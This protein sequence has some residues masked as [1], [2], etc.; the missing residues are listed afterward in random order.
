MKRRRGKKAVGILLAAALFFGG[1]PKAAEAAEDAPK[2]EELL[3]HYEFLDGGRDSSGNG[4]DAV[5]GNGVKV[6]GGVASLPGGDAGD[7]GF[8]TL[9]EGM[10]DGQDN[11]TVS[12]WI[13]DYDPKE[14]WLAAFFFGTPENSYGNPDSY[15]YFTPCEKEYFTLKSVI[16]GSVDEERPFDT[17]QGVRQSVNT[18]ACQGVWTHYAV[19]LTPETMICYM[20]G[21]AVGTASLTRAVSDFGTGL[22][23]YI[24]KSNYPDPLYRGDFKD[25]RIYKGALDEGSV[26]RLADSEENLQ[27]HSMT[28]DGN[29]VTKK[30]S[31]NLYGLFYEDINSAADGGLY[32][33]MVKNYSFENAYV[34]AGDTESAQFKQDGYETVADYKRHWTAS[35]ER[36][37]QVENQAPLNEK[38]KNYAVLTGNVTLQ[39][40]GFAPKSSPNAA[41]MPVKPYNA[42]KKTGIYTFSV[43]AKAL[44]GYEGKLKVKLIG[45]NGDALTGEKEIDL[46]ADGTWKKVSAELVSK[47]GENTK[48]KLALAVEGAAA[49]DRLC[50]DMVSV[51]PHDSYGYGDKNY[52]YG[53]GVRKDLL[54]LMMD[55][56]PKFMRFP[57][58]CIVEGFNWEGLYD[59]RDSVGPLEMRKCNTNRWENWGNSDHS[60]GYMQSFGFGYHELLTLCEDFH[61]EAFP[62][63]SAGV[64]CQYETGNVDAKTGEDLQR[65]IDMATDFLDYC[66]ADPA[67]NEWAAK[68]AENGHKEPF[69]VKYLGIGNENFQAKYFDNLDVIKEA[70]LKYAKTHYPERTLQIISSAGPSSGGENLEY[71]YDRLAQTMPGETLV[72]EHYYETESFMYNESD[73]YDYYR[74]ADQGG[75]DVFVGEYAVK[76][77]NKYNTALA[78]A[79]FITGLERNADVV[80]HISYAPLLY[81]V[82][83][84]NWSHDLIYFDEFDTAKSTNYY[85]QKMFANHY[86]TELIGTELK[87]QDAE[88]SGDK[89]PILGMDSAEGYIEKITVYDENGKVLLSDDFDNNENGWERFLE[90]GSG[91]SFFISGGRLI[92]RGTNGKNAVCLP[93]AKKEKWTNFRMEIEGAVKT[94]GAGGFWIGAGSESRHYSY[95]MGKDGMGTCMEVTRPERNQKDLKTKALGNNYANSRYRKSGLTRIL[96][97]DR[98]NITFNF[99]VD[100]K[101]EASY[102]SE[103]VSRSDTAKYDFSSDLNQYQTDIYQVV[104]RD[105][106]NIYVKLV[107]PDKNQKAIRLD[108]KN[109]RILEPAQ[110]EITTLTGE[111]YEANAIGSE[112][113][114]P[115]VFRQEIKESSLNLL[116]PAYSVNAIRI[117]VLPSADK[118]KL[119]EL[120]REAQS[121]NQADYTQESW[122]ILLKA[123]EKAEEVKNDGSALQEAVESAVMEL[124]SAIRNLKKAGYNDAGRE[125]LGVVKEVRALWTGGKNIEISWTAAENAQE[126]EIFRSYS[127]DLG[128]EKIAAGKN[129]SYLDKTAQAG[130]DIWYKVAA[131]SGGERGPESQA[132]QTYILKTPSGVKAKR[133]KKTVTVSFKKV[134]NASGYEIFRSAK[135]KG[136]YKKAAELKSGKKVKKVFKKM[137][138][139]SYFYRVRAYQK[140]NGRKIYTAYSKTVKAVVK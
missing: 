26:K 79:C 94:S 70:V 35:L 126:Y 28:I 111:L 18:S 89:I 5:I 84:Q 6:S 27:R 112:K 4:N 99:G 119:L 108:F 93:K 50:L 71:A 45:E 138:K 9:P 29:N 102:T 133:S 96:R 34:R 129:A 32:P 100:K 63:M 125:T 14:A 12:M 58:G 113:I 46:P 95:H 56:N 74:R 67:E 128:Y 75:S 135:K 92:F 85:V 66:W 43:Y 37:F 115:S 139:G 40:G 136:K 30:L 7:A 73:R 11:V 114:A 52:A 16:T 22:E 110:A 48:G 121:K 87:A 72:D 124:E 24:G 54:D 19:A 20:D 80:K 33:E 116:L 55:L 91:N 59:W 49:S 120:L 82:G 140:R 103:K 39:N 25:V 31:E 105:A 2:Q 117:P 62:V 64:L 61:M 88:D 69:D 90:S 44:Q 130:K 51:V 78:E 97:N 41:S 131:V 23:A 8:I 38:N 77:D 109:V 68:R 3:A 137:K 53:V 57:G 118:T 122:Q 104:N 36:N 15:F 65:F 106:E 86:G 60:W 10:F 107:N 98:M 134:K 17:E 123:V 42:E 127:R 47:V 76:N 101:L 132:V 21:K 81:K 13:R 1:W 83:S